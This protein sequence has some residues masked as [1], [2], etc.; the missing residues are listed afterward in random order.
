MVRTFSVLSFSFQECALQQWPL[1]VL[2]GRD[3]HHLLHL[4]SLTC[5]L[6]GNISLPLSPRKSSLSIYDI[7]KSSFSHRCGLTVLVIQADLFTVQG[8]L[9]LQ[10][11]AHDDTMTLFLCLSAVRLCKGGSCSDGGRLWGGCSSDLGTWAPPL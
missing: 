10:P 5:Y 7:K 2:L 8:G 3:S 11:R 9:W 4:L 1:S 6:L